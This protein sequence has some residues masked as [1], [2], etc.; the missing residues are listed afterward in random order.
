MEFETISSIEKL[1]TG[2]KPVTGDKRSI[3]IENVNTIALVSKRINE[4]TYQISD[5]TG[6]VNVTFQGDT[7]S[8][9]KV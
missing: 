4:N 1:L 9:L 3:P 6:S 8:N 2:E 7:P 5:M